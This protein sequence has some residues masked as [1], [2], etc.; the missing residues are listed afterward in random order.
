MNRVKNFSIAFVINDPL[1]IIYL[2][3]GCILCLCDQ[4]NL[5]TYKHMFI[6]YIV[7]SIILIS[8]TE[9]HCIPHCKACMAIIHFI[10]NIWSSAIAIYIILYQQTCEP[11]NNNDVICCVIV[12]LVKYLLLF[13]RWVTILSYTNIYSV[14]CL[15]FRCSKH[16]FFLLLHTQK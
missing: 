12:K 1:Y 7:H 16:I 11:L 3:H 9:T 4:S 2:G 5:Y 10:R 13:R 14:V 8:F 6:A 15:G